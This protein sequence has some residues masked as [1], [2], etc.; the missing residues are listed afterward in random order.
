MDIIGIAQILLFFGLILA[1]AKPLGG[2]MARVYEGEKTFLTPVIGRV[3]Q[4]CYR[5]FGVR[6]DDD[7]PW[8]VYAFA[9]LMFSLVGLLLTYVLL[10]LQG[11]LP[12]KISPRSARSPRRTNRSSS[13]CRM[14]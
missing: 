4:L 14:I 13:S 12:W 2:Y 1:C 8:T 6:E 7:M 10:R 11:M 5:L 3:E 9:M